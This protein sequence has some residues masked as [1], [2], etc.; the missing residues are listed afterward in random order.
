MSPLVISIIIPTFNER[1]NVAELIRRL[2]RSLVGVTW[3]AIFVDDDS[4]DGTLA[5][6]QEI[7]SKDTRVR[8]IHRIGRRGLSSAVVEGMLSTHAPFIAVID[9]DLQHD[10]TRLPL[11][12]KLLQ[13]GD[14]DIVVGSRYLQAGGLGDWTEDRVYISQIATKLAQWILP[15]PLSDPMSGFFVATRS[16]L[17]TSVRK[18]SNQGYKILLDIVLSSPVKPRIREVPYVFRPRLHG[19]SKLDFAIVVEYLFLLL[20]KTFGRAVPTRFI[21]FA[22]V[23]ALGVL[24]HMSIYNILHTIFGVSFAVSQAA[25]FVGAMTSNFYINNILTYRDKQLRGF[26]PLTTGLLSFYMVCGLAAASNIGVAS[27]LFEGHYSLQQSAISGILV[28]LVWNY[29]MASTFTWRK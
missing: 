4:S 12:L 16:A 27:V 6:L 26:W 22:L 14:C 20:D 19:E 28:G 9:A 17:E 23:G 15:I 29:T 5:A 18:L 3:E 25:G 10:E 1:D 21:L 8:Y 7:S 11:M 2:D 13:S 24:V